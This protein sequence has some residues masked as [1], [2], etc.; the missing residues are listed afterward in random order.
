MAFCD[1][2]VSSSVLKKTRRGNPW[3]S[4]CK[5]LFIKKTYNE[6][7]SSRNSCHASGPKK[8][9][10]VS[11]YYITS[12]SSYSMPKVSTVTF[13][14][15]WSLRGLSLKSV[16]VFTISSATS[17]PSITFPKAA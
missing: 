17:I 1:I 16:G 12:G 2:L 5:S 6:Y 4:L 14:I 8:N 10:L 13:L 15:F 9:T 7:P 3:I 11:A